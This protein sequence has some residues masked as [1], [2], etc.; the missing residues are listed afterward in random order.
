M[1]T[2]F[3][4]YTIYIQYIYKPFY[5]ACKTLSKEKVNKKKRDYIINKS[6]IIISC[7]TP[8]QPAG[9][10]QYL[11]MFNGRLDRIRFEILN[12][13]NYQTVEKLKAFSE[14]DNLAK[15]VGTVP[16]K[17]QGQNPKSKP[18][19]AISRLRGRSFISIILD[20]SIFDGC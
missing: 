3:L 17:S 1:N 2:H 14:R 5:F 20:K 9:N 8:R 7:R 16:S 11:L 10:P 12:P 18:G 4:T 6:N 19:F 15:Q 13:N